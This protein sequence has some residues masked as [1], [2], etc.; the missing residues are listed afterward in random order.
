MKKYGILQALE[1]K[2]DH[3]GVYCELRFSGN[4]KMSCKQRR[5]HVGW[6]PF[7]DDNGEPSQY[8]TSLD[9]ALETFSG[10]DV[11]DFVV[12]SASQCGGSSSSS[13]TRKHNED[14]KENRGRS[15]L[16]QK[17]EQADLLV[18]TNVMVVRP[19]GRVLP[20]SSRLVGRTT[21]PS[22]LLAYTYG[23]DGSQTH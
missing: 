16:A 6:K 7:L 2:S 20:F 1:G 22:T 4:Y 13:P 5:I 12:T 10:G 11:N 3:R 8:H 14:V 19:T 18:F 21:L 9:T 17:S 15:H 23:C